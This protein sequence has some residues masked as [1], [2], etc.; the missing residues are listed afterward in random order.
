MQARQ[1][2]I[3]AL[4]CI[5]SQLI[6]LHHFCAYGPLA[7]AL[8]RLAPALA[9]WFYDYARM[10]VQIF[11]VLGG[12]LAL[13]SLRPAMRG[14][15]AALGRALGLR[16]LRLA[17]PLMTALALAVAAAALA[18]VWLQAD[19]MPSPPRWGQALAHTLLL[20]DLID[21]EALSAGIWYVA[22]DLQ[23]YALLAVLLWLGQRGSRP[24]PALWLVA[25]LMLASLLVFN[26]QAHWDDWGLYFFGSYA[27]GALA[28]WAAGSRRALR[29]L[30]LLAALG[31]LTL[32]LDW[33]TRIALA[34]GVALLLGLMQ[35]RSRP[36]ASST[37]MAGHVLQRLGRSSYALFLVHF[38]VLMLANAL[39]AQLGQADPWAALLMLALGWAGSVALA[40]V[41]ERWV[42]TPLNRRISALSRR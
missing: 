37:G 41:F 9:G 35:W 33:R 7:D 36:A 8:H 31:L 27:L 4:K 13:Q 24:A 21:A 32:W 34:L 5:G 30:G 10:A 39:Y 3:D 1:T 42:E 19:F 25:G 28:G 26:R 15:A 12:Y 11:L 29:W 18:R 23:L 2:H 22:I 20:Q 40:L 16:Y 6:V 17:L 38:S 14:D